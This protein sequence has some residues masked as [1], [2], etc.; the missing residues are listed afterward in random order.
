MKRQV[1][2]VKG[3]CATWHI[4][5][6]GFGFYEVCGKRYGTIIDAHR[7]IRIAERRYL[8]DNPNS[9]VVNTNIWA[10]HGI[11]WIDDIDGGYYD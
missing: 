8:E 5:E 11:L 4:Y 1:K 10:D 7:A 6:D 9:P 2:T 3:H